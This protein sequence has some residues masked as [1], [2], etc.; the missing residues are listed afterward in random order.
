M[1]LYGRGFLTLTSLISPTSKFFVSTILPLESVGPRGPDGPA[2]TGVHG[3][4]IAPGPT[5]PS[6]NIMIIILIIKN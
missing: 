4:V 3:D 5:I 1:N 6:V 2:L